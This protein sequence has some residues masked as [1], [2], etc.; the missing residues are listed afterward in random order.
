MN[1]QVKLSRIVEG[2][3]MQSDESH[4]Y[5]DLQTGEVVSVREDDLAAT[6]D[7]DL[8]EDE[9]LAADLADW[10]KDPV[11]QA[12]E[13][14]EHA[15]ERYLALPSKF[16][17]HEY[18]IMDEFCRSIEDRR[19]SDELRSK[20]RGSGA[21]RRFKD[22]IHERDV[23]DRWYQFRAEA[24]RQIA[25]DWCDG[26]GLAY[27]DDTHRHDEQ[28][29]AREVA[30]KAKLYE[31]L[32]LQVRAVLEGERDP[33]ANA[34]NAASAVFHALPQVSWVGF[35]FVKGGELVV[36]P[37]QGKPACT[38]IALGRGVCGR[39]AAE[40]K[41][42]VVPDVREFP[43]HIACDPEANSEIVVPIVQ[44]GRL[45]GV[46]DLD[47]TFVDRFDDQDAAGLEAIAAIYANAW[48]AIGS[49]D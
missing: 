28:K 41:T 21:F 49:S 35:Y 47:S 37:F 25:I 30:E 23:A 20:I 27:V 13:V 9:E 18:S 4:R 12:R 32:A 31:E 22:A 19:L 38:R 34:A 43:G 14:L 33:I 8:L 6:E 48:D 7:D 3:H 17:I 46:L 16:D 11:E 36:G 2:M 10:E 29:R 26:H 1:A 40:R 42:L 44:E 5:L 39:A 24:F 15:G 45:V